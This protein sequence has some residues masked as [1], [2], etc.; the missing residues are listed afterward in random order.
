MA[1]Q[2]NGARVLPDLRGLSAREALRV[3]TQ[4]GLAARLTGSGIVTT[5]SPA[6]GAAVDPGAVCD[7]R[8]ERTPAA[9][10][11][12]SESLESLPR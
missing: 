5:Q 1:G 4:I 2:F 8:L 6:P 3:L 12:V 9:S 11:I 7:L 10:A